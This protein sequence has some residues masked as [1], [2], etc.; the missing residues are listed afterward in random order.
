M[1]E[2][3]PVRKVRLCECFQRNVLE[4]TEFV[5]KNVYSH[6]VLRAF[7]YLLNVLTYS[8]EQSPS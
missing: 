3:G 7:T 5:K 8:M 2:K 1:N 6:G 4:D